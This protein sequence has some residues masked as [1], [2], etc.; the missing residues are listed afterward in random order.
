MAFL[1]SFSALASLSDSDLYYFVPVIVF[2]INKLVH[3]R[4]NISS[5]AAAAAGTALLF[6]YGVITE[7]NKDAMI[8]DRSKIRRE[9]KRMASLLV[10]ERASDAQ[11]LT[12]IGFDSKKDQKVLSVQNHDVS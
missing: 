7:A 1:N 3:F 8:I 9:R 11:H 10:E 4:F 5:R 12:C 6:D 2:F